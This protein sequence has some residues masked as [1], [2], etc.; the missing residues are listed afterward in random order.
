MQQTATQ[1]KSL[2]LEI[3]ETC[4]I[5]IN[6][7]QA[8]TGVDISNA[9]K[10]RGVNNDDGDPIRHSNVNEA[11]R[12]Y[13]IDSF[14]PANPSSW[15]MTTINPYQDVNGHAISAPNGIFLYHTIGAD[16][17]RYEV[18]TIMPPTATA[19]TYT[20]IASAPAV[21][22]VSTPPQA[23]PVKVSSV[24]TDDTKSGNDAWIFRVACEDANEDKDIFEAVCEKI[25]QRV[26]NAEED[27]NEGVDVSDCNEDI[28]IVVPARGSSPETK[29]TTYKE[30]EKAFKKEEIPVPTG[31]QIM[32]FG[33]TPTIQLPNHHLLI[34]SDGR[35]RIPKTLID[36]IL[37]GQTLA[38]IK[39][40]VDKSVRHQFKV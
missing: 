5:F 16:I 11:V 18:P 32:V 24:F 23:N 15:A 21:P 34:E 7:F 26:A 37:N 22:S 1:Q 6:R 28:I 36:Q 30:F 10:L 12:R 33:T 2:S 20:P 39:G 27:G 17:S 14:L 13:M 4:Q 9:L 25:I 38:I 29:Y 31:T 35:V 40:D 8:F 19:P 3:I